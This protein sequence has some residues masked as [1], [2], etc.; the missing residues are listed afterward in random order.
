MEEKKIIDGVE[1]YTSILE[2]ALEHCLDTINDTSKR[3]E[4]FAKEEC[5]KEVPVNN[6]QNYLMLKNDNERNIYYLGS[7]HFAVSY[8]N[9]EAR[10]KDTR[11]IP[12]LDIKT[13]K[14]QSPNTRG[15]FEYQG[16]YWLLF[17]TDMRLYGESDDCM[18]YGVILNPELYLEKMKK[19][20]EMQEGFFRKIMKLFS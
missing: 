2:N 8:K 5:A 20:E 7:N 17:S 18:L 13:R 11:I 12:T 3:Y 1:F 14:V 15:A 9:E 16:K 6:E 4:Y 19:I 10:T